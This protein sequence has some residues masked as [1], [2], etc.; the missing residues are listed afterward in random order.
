MLANS[1]EVGATIGKAGAVATKM[2]Q[3]TLKMDQDSS[4][5]AIVE[6]TW[7]LLGWF[8]LRS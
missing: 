7:E 1:S 5:I 2:G 4:K 3:D 6:S 8:W